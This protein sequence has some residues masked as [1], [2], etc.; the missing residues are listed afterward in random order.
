MLTV[1][2]SRGEDILTILT[3][4]NDKVSQKGDSAKKQVSEGSFTLRKRLV[5]PV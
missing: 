1:S 5:F 4:V 3:T 2:L